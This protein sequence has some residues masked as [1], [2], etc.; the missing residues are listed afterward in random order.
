M[1]FR[2]MSLASSRLSSLI[3]WAFFSLGA[4]MI[5]GS[6]SAVTILGLLSPAEDQ[7]EIF[8]E[9]PTGVGSVSLLTGFPI[10]AGSIGIGAGDGLAITDFSPSATILDCSDQTT[11]NDD[12]SA[13]LSFNC[14]S[15]PITVRT[16]VA[17]LGI[18]GQGTLSVT[19]DSVLFL[20]GVGL[21]VQGE[22]V[23]TVSLSGELVRTGQGTPDPS[24]PHMPEP[25]AAAL[26]VIGVLAVRRV[27][28]Y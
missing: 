20:D 14:F 28:A 4:L 3:V 26:F 22:A 6:A 19:E 18:S 16:L 13:R 2:N 11:S 23:P 17:T 12:S 24:D 9:P 5:S 27:L 8:L 21:I 1:G 7:V 25:T 10:V 15:T